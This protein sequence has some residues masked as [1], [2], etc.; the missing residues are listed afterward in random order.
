M[1]W[2]LRRLGERRHWGYLALAFFPPVYVIVLLWI[3]WDCLGALRYWPES[4]LA[5]GTLMVSPAWPVLYWR[6]VLGVGP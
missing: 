3:W 6:G 5:A 4:V 1:N 2:L